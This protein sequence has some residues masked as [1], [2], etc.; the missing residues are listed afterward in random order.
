MATDVAW[1]EQDPGLPRPDDSTA[2]GGGLATLNLSFEGKGARVERVSLMCRQLAASLNAGMAYL[3]ALEAVRSELP[4]GPLAEQMAEITDM[5]AKGGSL[6][7]AMAAFPK[8]F[9]ARAVALVRVGEDGGSLPDTLIRLADNLTRE[10][11]IKRK[12]R[13]ALI[14]PVLTFVVAV[15]VLAISLMFV[16]P[17]FA[18]MISEFRG[19]MPTLTL[20][21]F[22][23]SNA[24]RGWWWLIMLAA[25][26]AGFLFRRW[27]ATENGRYRWHLFLIRLPRIG[28]RV[29][30]M[31]ATASFLRAYATMT[32]AG[33]SAL[34]SLPVAA[35]TAGNAVLERSVGE[36]VETLAASGSA[37]VADALAEVGALPQLAIGMLAAGES[38]GHV[39]EMV[40]HVAVLF[41]ERVDA[42]VTGIERLIQPIMIIVV[43]AIVGFIV[44]AMYM[45][46]FSLYDQIR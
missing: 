14:T 23:V 32:H 27:V 45:P 6:S 26:V 39:E 31:G 8:T 42:E 40:E 13:V 12:M 25:I 46:M 9:D 11:A 5:I 15:L 22:N 7:R 24:V 18:A 3:E 28:P 29:V 2:A 41:E 17:K 43:G 30:V 10:A 34:E 16:V 21:L 36:A 38:A 33:V 44:I 20:I 37:G 19:H 4:D 1:Q 35:E